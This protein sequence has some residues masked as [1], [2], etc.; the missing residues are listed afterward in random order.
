M[1]ELDYKGYDVLVVDDEPDNLDAFRFAF[2]KS[3]RLH[4]AE[5][6]AEALA[7]IEAIEP[8]VIVAD[9]RMP[10]MSG[11]ELLRR[12]KER[13]DDLFGVLLTAYADID[14]L[15]D[16]VNSGAV[17]RYVQKPWDSKEMTLIL[18]QGIQT[19]VTLRENRR[20]REQLAQYAGYLDSQQRDPLDFGPIVGGGQATTSTLELV[21]EV[22]PTTTAVLV[23]G[24]MGTEK[25][26]VAR[27]IHVGSPREDRPFVTVTAA[28]FPGE[29]LEREIFGYR[30]HAFEGA[31]HDR[32]GRVEV[33]NGGTLYLHELGAT[34][35]SLQA[36]LLRLLEE[37]QSE[38]IGE[39]TPRAVDVRL[40]V[41]CTPS[42]EEA[43]PGLIPELRSRLS[44]F[45]IRLS[46]LRER[47]DDIRPLAEHFLRKH[48][49]RNALAATEI[50][51]AAVSAL[52]GYRWPGNARELENVL[53]RAAILARGGVIEPK[54]LELEQL[55]TS[56]SPVEPLTL[57]NRLDAIER[58]ELLTALERHGGNKAEVARA[59]GIHRTTL[60]Y[61]LKKLGI[62]A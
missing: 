19:C 39:T 46:P 13:V 20:M 35:R 3:F 47:R 42:L 56:A 25:E 61:R 2:R 5:G 37:G 41:S 34:D 32:A 40:V 14:V 12:A 8:A 29:A 9:Q 26:V 49:R 28:A 38:R 53:E 51:A 6:G 31:F 10:K 57:S 22:A 52:E 33:A 62:D 43:S 21:A 11:I 1:R 23:E 36:R 17:D 15:V 4:Y 60:Y 7:M 44:V 16:A 58:K 45:P 18:R 30:R 54:H 24:E 59:L 48:A 55:A 27:A 50:A